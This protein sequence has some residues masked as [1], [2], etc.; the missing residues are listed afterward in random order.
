MRL[1][2][3]ENSISRMMMKRVIKIVL[4]VGGQA[5]FYEGPV[6]EEND[7]FITIQDRKDGNIQLS[8]NKIISI[9]EVTQ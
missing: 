6:L 5:Y 8:K 2:W 1:S 4:D 3:Q 9:K 7:D